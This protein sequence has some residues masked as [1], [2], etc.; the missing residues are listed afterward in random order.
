[1]SSRNAIWR[2]STPA[3]PKMPAKAKNAAV[4]EYPWSGCN[5]AQ[6]PMIAVTTSSEWSVREFQ[7]TLEYRQ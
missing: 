3:I 2:L 1:M 6:K 5:V 4:C 7:E